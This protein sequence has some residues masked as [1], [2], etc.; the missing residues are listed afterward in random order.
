MRAK[1]ILRQREH[2]T[3]AKVRGIRQKLFEDPVVVSK[4]RLALAPYQVLRRIRWVIGMGAFTK[5]LVS[6]AIR[7]CFSSY[8]REDIFRSSI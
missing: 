6:S 5:T 1:S 7:D 3:S 2:D 8:S 4:S